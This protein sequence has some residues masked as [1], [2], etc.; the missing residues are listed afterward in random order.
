MLRLAAENPTWGHRRVQGELL[1]L[2]YR[3]AASTVWKILHR[4]GIDPAPRRSG[5]TW[6]QFLT[7][8][9]HTILAC[10]F[11]TVGTVFLER[12]YGLF[13]VELAV[14]DDRGARLVR[15][16]EGHELL[17]P[18]ERAVDAGLVRLDDRIHDG[19]VVGGKHQIA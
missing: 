3:V 8:Q 1:G 11:F 17:R 9:A 15:G 19:V 4:A 14:R 18:A 7:A 13:F 6:K 16:D 10:D 12:I 5:P 2:G